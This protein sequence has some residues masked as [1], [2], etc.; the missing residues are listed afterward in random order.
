MTIF[1]FNLFLNRDIRMNASV[2]NYITRSDFSNFNHDYMLKVDVDSVYFGHTSLKEVMKGFGDSV[3]SFVDSCKSRLDN[4]D[5]SRFGLCLKNSGFEKVMINVNGVYPDKI[6]L[7]YLPNIKIMEC[8]VEGISPRFYVNMY[9]VGVGKVRPTTYFKNVEVKALTALLNCARENCIPML[10]TALSVCNRGNDD[11]KKIAAQVELEIFCDMH[12][13]ESMTGGSQDKRIK[14]RQKCLSNRSARIFASEFDSALKKYA[15]CNDEDFAK[16]F[17]NSVYV[18]SHAILSSTALMAEL[19]EMRSFLMKL[20]NGVFYCASCAGCK[21]DFFTKRSSQSLMNFDSSDRD[22]MERSSL[23]FERAI[24]LKKNAVLQHL[25]KCLFGNAGV[26]NNEDDD[27]DEAVLFSHNVDIGIEVSP[28][29]E[30]DSFFLRGE[31]ARDAAREMLRARNT[32]S[33]PESAVARDAEVR[34]GTETSNIGPST[35]PHVLESN[36]VLSPEDREMLDYGTSLRFSNDHVFDYGR[37]DESSFSRPGER[38]SCFF[39]ISKMQTKLRF[40]SILSFRW[41]GRFV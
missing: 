18:G 6:R 36:L 2:S 38:A 8:D 7:D 11:A 24:S 10:K 20:N 4:S 31:E 12:L 37:D 13:F 33:I 19:A 29:N 15:T 9:F 23:A 41:R 1:H 3:T 21:Q 34:N 27:D 16:V 17:S 26:P 30:T 32:T 14:N 39:L 22:M 40:E 35:N 25:K 5:S 28:R